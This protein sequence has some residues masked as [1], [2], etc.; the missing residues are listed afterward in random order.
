MYYELISRINKEAIEEA[1][2][3]LNFVIPDSILETEP[4]FSNFLENPYICIVQLV[5]SE[6]GT[7]EIGNIY[8]HVNE[9]IE[10]VLNSDYTPHA[11][12]LIKDDNNSVIISFDM[13]GNMTSSYLINKDVLYNN[14]LGIFMAKSTGDIFEPP[15]RES[16]DSIL[17]QARQAWNSLGVLL[18]Y[19]LKRD[20]RKAVYVN[21]E[22]LIDV[23]VTSN[24]FHRKEEND[25]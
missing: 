3:S 6:V 5:Y 2:R 4:Y 23:Q 17:E 13:N 22:I 21:V 1:L 7:Y 14:D 11:L 24:Q 20:G 16:A 18:M 9:F 10:I 8:I 15:Y 12:A 25:E 19:S